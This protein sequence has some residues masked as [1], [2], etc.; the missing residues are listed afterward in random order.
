MSQSTAPTTSLSPSYART[1]V[2]CT[3]TCDGTLTVVA[4]AGSAQVLAF[5]ASTATWVTHSATGLTN[6]DP[7]Q[8]SGDVVI[9]AVA[10]SDQVLGFSGA[11]LHARLHRPHAG[12]VL[13]VNV[14]VVAAKT[15][16]N[17][18]QRPGLLPAHASC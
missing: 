6:T 9:V 17:V 12:E 4:V 7:V 5:R 8:V 1:D 13:F 16:R 11:T 15:S 2:P 10:A 18:R 3:K 14:E